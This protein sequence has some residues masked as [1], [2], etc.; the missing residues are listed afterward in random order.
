M[1]FMDPDTGTYSDA[2]FGLDTVSAL[3]NEPSIF[4]SAVGVVT[5][6]IPLTALSIINTFANT[7]IDYGNWALGGAVW[8]NAFS[9]WS[10]AK[11]LEALGADSYEEYYKKHE[12]GI[13]T[14]SLLVGSLV[15]G[16][17]GV[18]AL[19]AI[20]GPNGVMGPVMGRATGIFSKVRNDA[21]EKAVGD[22]NAGDAALF[23]LLNSQ[24][25]KAIAAGFG[26]QALQALAFEL[27]VA[28]T[29]EASPLLDKMD[30]GDIATNMFYG[31]LLGGVVG[32]SIESLF[33]RGAIRR[34]EVAADVATKPAEL[35]TQYGFATGVSLRGTSIAGDRVVALLDSLERIP[36]EDLGSSTLATKKIAD[37]QLRAMN[38]SKFLLGELAGKGN[39][40][41]SSS[42]LDVLVEM[43]KGGATKDDIFEKLAGL[44]K[45]SR[46][47]EPAAT[48]VG[49]YFYI[50]KF[51]SSK[52]PNLTFDDLITIAPHTSSDLSFRY[53]V[54][55]FAS[56]T[57]TKATD[58]FE[59]STGATLP[60]YRN[61]TEAYSDGADIFIDSKLQVHVNPKSENI[62]QVARP[63]ESRVTTVGEEATRTKEGTVTAREGKPLTGA[64]IVLNTVTKDITSDAIPVV[65]DFG[66]VKLISQGLLY[67]NKLS[68]QK[69]ET[70]LTVETPTIEAN[71][72]YVWAVSRGVRAGDT[73]STSDIPML[74]ALWRQANSSGQSFEAFM[75]GL[76]QRK[77][78]F[79]DGSDLPYS[80]QEL[81]SRI[82]GAKDDLVNELISRNPNMSAEEIAI[83]ANVPEKYIEDAFHATSPKDFMVD[84]EQWSKVNHIKLEYD[85]GN[86]HSPDGQILRGLI[87]SQYRIRVIQDALDN[88]MAKQ[89]GGEW[90]QYKVNGLSSKDA[91]IAGAGA[92]FLTFS[93]AEYGTLEQ[94]VE[95]IG[96]YLSQRMLQERAAYSDVLAPHATALRN[97]PLASAEL[98]AFVAVRR[99]TGE[100]YVFLPKEIAVKYWRNE[101]TVVLRSSL[102]KDR[103]GAVVDWN[104]D[105]TPEGFLPGAAVAV[106]IGV[107]GVPATGLHTFYDLSPKV[108]AWERAQMEVNNNILVSRNNWY[109]AMGISRNKELGTLYAPPIDTGKYPYFALVRARPGTAFADDSV[110][111]ITANTQASLEQKMA[112]LR[113][114]YDVFTK[115]M[116]ADYKKAMGDYQ[117]DRNFMDNRV[118]S[119]L[120]RRGILN[121]IYPDTRAELLIQQYVEHN[122]RQVT[123][124]LRDYVEMGNAQVFAEIRA[125]GAKF[126]GAATSQTGGLAKYFARSQ[127]NPYESYVKTALAVG[128][129]DEYRLW[130]DA[131]EKL[132]AFASSSWTE[133]KKAIISVDKGKLPLE[134]ATPIMERMGLGNGYGASADIFNAYQNIANK[135]PDAKVLSRLVAAGNLFQAA[136]A[137]RLDF[138]QSLINLISTPI[139]TMAETSSILRKFK[140]SELLTELP[141]GSGRSVLT[142]T[143]AIYGAINDLWNPTIRAEMLPFLERT[144]I[145]RSTTNEYFQAVNNLAIPRSGSNT[146]KVLEGINSAIETGSKLTGSQ[147]SENLGRT[148]SALTARRIFMAEGYGG[149]QLEDSILTFVNRVHGN[150]VASQRPV[151]FQG[152]IGQAMGLFQTYQ[153]NFFQQAFRYIENGEAKTLATMAALQTGLFG[154]QGLPGF[155]AINQHI[156]GTAAGNPSH[157]DLYSSTTNFFDKK[158]GDYLL[159]GV[160][161]NWL[162]TGL[163]SRGDI[164][165][166]S[167]SV[168]PI[169]PLDYPAIRG[170]IQFIGNLLS[171]ADKV[172]QGG[173]LGASLLQGLEHN[174]LSR[175]L[176]GLGQLMQGYVSTASG[177]LVSA[178]RPSMGSAGREGESGWGEIVSVANFSR[179][180]GARPL[181]EAINMDMLYRSTL[182]KAKDTSRMERLG[183][184]VKETLAGNRELP[185]ERMDRFIHEYTN[186]GGEIAH[187]GQQI[188]RWSQDA[189]VAKANEIFR[190][191]QKPMART[192]M[193]QM[194]GVPLPDFQNRGNLTQVATPPV[195]A[196]TS[197]S[198]LVT[199]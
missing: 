136:T 124:L 182:Y 66:E 167:V 27:S 177:Q 185:P 137:V 17:A 151:A 61:A 16:T 26:D 104:K 8:G 142:T 4:S 20:Q 51:S 199:P 184:A 168:L 74:E 174:G 3:N 180:A 79:S 57:V 31:V 145:T 115:D 7:G 22:I 165:P 160:A 48:P 155:Q 65:G 43:R 52:L 113:S 130:N 78:T 161:S 179:L 41:L 194:G 148:I 15:P 77:V 98:G 132:E 67:G 80:P 81:L 2:A 24:K 118:N 11:E 152:P 116:I 58:T 192:Q 92:K 154:L 42:L 14:A 29:M 35:T 64:P 91:T 197:R 70:V 176:S 169:N 120:N 163:Y 32:G 39:E 198:G 181:D 37:T 127:D 59:T 135:L 62:S 87:D 75:D 54:K 128:P 96:R 195:S 38:E 138:W 190:H 125:M 173:S 100:E 106:E 47:D 133:A 21:I 13:E 84:P 156:V 193:E 159:Y 73:I 150:Y 166:R 55:P 10:T 102:V 153:F 107:S 141:D 119:D 162:N 140:N 123:R 114:D 117:Y 25:T 88:A 97:D 131:Q 146:E 76:R 53:Q 95:R 36:V 1:A 158:L 34:A 191:L 60:R 108:A 101:D 56:P 85:I 129:R 147:W 72:R 183:E 44:A 93:N 188:M 122:N 94:Q 171:T 50:N 149:Q 110:A 143:K 86:T 89:F 189:N 121:D 83:R 99:R 172:V 112:S 157:A 170:G 175:P 111:M 19:K 90:T 5:K 28:G 126:E 186:A 105:F 23:G 196:N 12:E 82:T 187:F 144:N 71:A 30:M 49:D 6:G 33:V 164:N 109:S 103:T 40:D 68:I 63:G 9:R 178:I 69:L 45:I 134:Q 46:I 139:L 18:K